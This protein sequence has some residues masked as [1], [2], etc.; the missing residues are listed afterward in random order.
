MFAISVASLFSMMGRYGLFVSSLL[1]FIFGVVLLTIT[2]IKNKGISSYLSTAVKMVNIASVAFLLI[3][4]I[5]Q[6]LF[7]Y[8]DEYSFWGTA[9]KVTKEL[10]ALYTY[11]PHILT[12]LNAIPPASSILSYIM[13]FFSPDFYDHGLYFAYAFAALVV[14]GCIAEIVENYTEKK[15]LSP[16]I[17]LIL[18]LGV[19]LQTYHGAV[20][21]YSS[22]S[23]AYGTAMSD[24]TIAVFALATLAL[25]FTDRTRLFY[26]LGIIPLVF[27][28]D[29]GI[30]FA[31]LTVGVIFSFEFFAK[32]KSISK[33]IVGLLLGITITVGVY[34][35]WDAYSFATL[36]RNA[37]SLID[38]E[39]QLL[40]HELKYYQNP[41]VENIETATVPQGQTPTS[42]NL[43]VSIVGSIFFEESRSDRQNEVLSEIR[44]QFL[45]SATIAGIKDYILFIFIISLGVLAAVLM[46]KKYRIAFIISN[47]GLIVGL[48]LYIHSISYF[49][50][51]FGDGM[52][53]YPRYTVPYYYIYLYFNLIAF[54]IVSVKRF[55][56]V[57]FALI[58]ALCIYL[59]F[60]LFSLGVDNTFI[61]APENAYSDILTEKK[62]IERYGDI[63]GRVLMIAERFKDYHYMTNMYIFFPTVVNYNDYAGGYD[64]SLGFSNED[65]VEE[66]IIHHF[67]IATDEEFITIYRENFDLLYISHPQEEFVSS[68]G[69]LFYE[70]IKNNTLY[71]LDED[72]MFVEVLA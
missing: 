29:V 22:Q 69:N 47:I 57:S 26:L 1:Y 30:V 72:N 5:N 64:F 14:F 7:Y 15:F 33:I 18:M 13:Q 49:I 3:Y 44:T 19:F 2:A 63:D 66:D 39:E 60:N 59:V 32:C 71:T 55:Y 41:S 46:P 34:Y 23:Y 70:E 12:H 27:I 6:P 65:M 17:F 31:V 37:E 48:F 61:A 11:T 21:G 4:A 28:K 9:A 58:C 50:S 35:A 10:G 67:N 25:Y 56:R 51:G 24:F 68:Y 8:W 54:L 45:S 20:Q 52:V 42:D 62:A 53:E 36:Q 40:P 16:I 43:I 38:G